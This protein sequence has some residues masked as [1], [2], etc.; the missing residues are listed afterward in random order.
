MHHHTDRIAHTTAFVT[1]VVEHWLDCWLYHTLL[2]QI[3]T[4]S[5]LC[6]AVF[7]FPIRF[8]D[9]VVIG[10]GMILVLCL[11]LEIRSPPTLDS[12]KLK[13]NFIRHQI[14]DKKTKQN[15][16]T[17]KQTN[18]QDCIYFCINVYINTEHMATFQWQNVHLR[19]SGRKEGMVYLMTHSTHFIY[20]YM[21]SDI[22]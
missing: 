11:P 21:V 13:F 2:F 17:N 19:S 8:G 4:Y 20:G 5:T 10:N 12:T 18:K 1:P 15:K 14:Y 9:V 7:R 6:L 22:W 3:H 16:Q